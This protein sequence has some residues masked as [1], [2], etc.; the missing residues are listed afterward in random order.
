M[1]STSLTCLHCHQLLRT[2]RPVEA[3]QNVKCPK[4]G[5][6]FTAPSEEPVKASPEESAKTY[7]FS[8][9]PSRQAPSSP[10]HRTKRKAVAAKAELEDDEEDEGDDSDSLHDQEAE[11]QPRRKVRP[12]LTQKQQKGNSLLVVGVIAGAILV[13]LLA[14]GAGGFYW[15]HNRDKNSGKIE[16]PMA[17]IPAESSFV[18]GADIGSLASQPA[19]A[20][21]AD[22]AGKQ[23]I[24]GNFLERLKTKTGMEFKDLFNSLRL[25]AGTSGNPQPRGRQN[26]PRLTLVGKSRI[27]LDQLKLRDACNEPTAVRFEGRT[28]FRIK[29]GQFTLLY[30]PSKWILVMSSMEEIKLQSLILA[31]KAGSGNAPPA[32]EFGPE[33]QANHF[34][35]EAKF[36]ESSKA[37]LGMLATVGVLLGQPSE[38]KRIVDGLQ[39]ASA[40]G[41]WGSAEGDRATFTAAIK[42]DDEKNAKSLAGALKRIWESQSMSAASKGAPST[43]ERE[44]KSTLKFST[45]GPQAQATVTLSGESLQS[46]GQ[47]LMLGA[48]QFQRMASGGFP[49]IGPPGGP[50]G[51]RQGGRSRRDNPDNDTR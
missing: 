29:E 16:D 19:F 13:L 28:Y 12:K 33:I 47:Q 41:L 23:L 3:G 46:L 49:A 48:A 39:H 4:C 36:N 1:S 10:P 18:L 38:I 27:P 9:A 45:Q 51:G 8:E 21:L 7:G 17:F 40:A 24:S 35:A 34:W 50:Q 43:L 37:G 11:A 32:M 20:G 25:C 22:N 42:C 30:M 6:I 26:A 14:G 31:E 15:Y 44:L 2:S 5:Q